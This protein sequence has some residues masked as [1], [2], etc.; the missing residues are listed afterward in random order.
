MGKTKE[1]DKAKRPPARRRHGRIGLGMIVSLVFSGMILGVL[2]LSLSESAIPLPESVRSRIEARINT[3]LGDDQIRIGQVDVAVGRDGVPRVALSNVLIGNPAGGA[4][5]VLNNVQ[6]RLSP[7]RMLRG[8]FGAS[9]LELD[10]AQITIRRTASGEFA[11]AAG[12]ASEAEAQSLSEILDM[13][14]RVFETPALAALEDVYAAG[15]VLTLEDAR[16]GRLWQA[17]NASMILRRDGKATTLTLVSDVFNGT[18]DVAEVQLSLARNPVTSGV[19]VGMAVDGMPAADIALQAP[20]L[21]WL[22]VLDAPLSGA[23]RT[24]IGADGQVTSLAGK[25]DIKEGALRPLPDVAPV[26]FQSAKAYFTF[27]ADRQRIDFS[28]ITVLSDQGRL[29]ASG[30]TYLA[31][32]A[33]PWP[34]AFIGQFRAS[35]LEYDGAG[36]FQGP[37]ALA[38]I[39]ADL[40]LRLDPFTVEMGQFSFDDGEAEIRATGRVTAE[41]D[42]WHVAV[43][44]HARQ[45]HSDRVL[46]LWPT[47]VAPITRGWISSNLKTGLLSDVSAGI[48]FQQ[49]QE[50]DAILSFGFS[51]GEVQFLRQMPPMTGASGRASL[52]EDRFTL[53]L[54]SGQVDAGE[55][56]AIDT[57]GSVFS[58]PDTRPKPATGQIEI[59][60]AGPLT[61]ALTVLNNPPLRIMERA[62][63]DPDFASAEANATALITL[64]LAKK[65]PAGSIDYRVSAELRDVESDRIAPGRFLSA[66]SL[67]L[68]VTPEMIGLDGPVSLDGVPVRA[69][70]RQPLGAEAKNGAWVDG[71]VTLSDETMQA[72]GVP[73]PR[74]MIGGQG[75]GQ[76]RLDLPPEGAAPRLTLSSDLAGLSLAF[77]GLGWSKPRRTTGSFDLVAELGSV[78]EVERLSLDAAGL[79]LEGDIDLGEGG[80]FAGA[81]FSPFRLGGWLDGSVSL[82]PRGSGLTPEIALTNGRLDLRR[83]PSGGRGGPGDG[84]PID[85]SLNELVVTDDIS[86]SPLSGQFKTGQAGLSG[87][88]QARINGGTPVRGTLAPTSGGTGIRIQSENAGGVF[89][90]AGLTPNGQAGT[91]DLVLTPVKGAAEGTYNGSFLVEKFRLRKAPLLADLLDAVSIVGLIDQLGGPGIL[92]E[93]LDGSFRLT[94]ERLTLQR[95]AAVGGSIGISA[96]GDYDFATKRLNFQG[97]ISPVY[98]LNAIGAVLTRRGEGLFGFNYRMSGTADAPQISVNPLSI[99]APG[100]VREIFRR[101]PRQE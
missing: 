46:A 32:L 39:R 62:G 82:T 81:R 91:L 97:V 27:D 73:L 67:S 21:A 59:R 35:E 45:I 79:S 64:P 25:L 69:S 5:A 95:A 60:A 94:R 92:F 24:E 86:L 34:G 43:D 37:L 54:H 53:V 26:G 75:Q 11:F 77:D 44:S 42:G 99:L 29:A 93:T 101:Q 98:F 90:D 14:D 33:G 19:S 89:R 1:Q 10:G 78:P 17:T 18:D 41:T 51:D 100:A 15:I 3:R 84:A 40:R 13:V 88:F 63:R 65:V 70:W 68:E 9:R 7:E 87:S 48:R 50:P 47:I 96:D 52:G 31:E 72:L 57:A 6:A 49:G 61:A 4:V 30:H 74:G 66:E 83:L 16:S 58:V 55:A 8:E 76:F 38:G 85:L 71:T 28:D 2:F 80:A 20:V 56:G 22:G 36:V 23:V 12:A